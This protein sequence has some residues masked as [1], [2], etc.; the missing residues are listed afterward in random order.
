GSAVLVEAARAKALRERVIRHHVRRDVPGEIRAA[1]PAGLGVAQI[2]GIEVVAVSG[3]VTAR[4]RHAGVEA[5]EARD[6]AALHGVFELVMARADREC[7]DLRNDIE[8]GGQEEGRLLGF[9]QL[10]LKERGAVVLNTRALH[11]RARDRS[12]VRQAADFAIR[13]TR[14]DGLVLPGGLVIQLVVL[15][16]GADDAAQAPVVR[17][18]EAQ[19]VLLVQV[20]L[21]RVPGGTRREAGRLQAWGG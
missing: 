5:A 20:L 17:R 19:F 21:G 10:I 15:V 9:A 18:T 6:H 8:V 4:G 3:I 11:V 1:L 14:R 16:V 12:D 2:I 13:G 7:Q